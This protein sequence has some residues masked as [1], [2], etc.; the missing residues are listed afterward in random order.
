VRGLIHTAFLFL[1][2]L[3]VA[4]FGLS[5]WSALGLVVLMLL[6]RW[7]IAL[8]TFVIPPKVP[9]IV[10]ETISASHF[11]EK[12]RWNMDV[13]GIDY[14]EKASGGTLGAFFL[15][16]TVPRLKIKTGAV[17][18]QIGNSPE[19]LR[20]LWGAFS[21]QE[22]VDVKHLE[23]TPERLALEK[24]LDRYGANLQ[25]WIY[26]ELLQDRE[27]NLQLWGANSPDIAAWQR[28]AL[29]VLQPL[30]AAL[31]RRSFRI[32]PTNVDKARQHIEGLLGEL[33]ATLADGRASIL[34][35]DEHNFTDYA[36][37]GLSGLW[38]QAPGY[39]GGKA[40]HVQVSRDRLP[41]KLRADVQRWRDDNSRVVAWVERLY[42][43]ERKPK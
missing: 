23:P 26:S 40:D 22:D 10:L 2:P 43:E 35:G 31:I 17:R 33:D 11:V 5:V 38:I 21:A 6:W 20:Y 36:F 18:S 12:V 1:L 8:S 37:A 13:A 24:R 4:W 41:A 34:G 7:L 25:V 32:T 15:G 27:L 30:L 29:R 3:V 28:L 16:R 14:V 42:E 39:G 19:I 9:P